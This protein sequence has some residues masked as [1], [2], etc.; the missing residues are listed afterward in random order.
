LRL[1]PFITPQLDT[2][3]STNSLKTN[4][5][6]ISGTVLHMFSRFLTAFKQGLS[7]FCD[8]ARQSGRKDTGN[9]LWVFCNITTESGRDAAVP[10]AVPTPGA[11]TTRDACRCEWA[12]I[13]LLS[14]CSV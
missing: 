7:H 14:H 5:Q 9:K 8:S 2:S 1:P 13:S 10:T 12:A 11:P 3:E 6:G 4:K